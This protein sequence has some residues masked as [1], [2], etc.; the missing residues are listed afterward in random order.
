MAP[1]TLQRAGER[2]ALQGRHALTVDDG[3]AHLAAGLAGLGI[4]GLSPNSSEWVAW[5]SLVALVCG[6]ML[7]LARVLRLGFLGDFLSASVL[8]GFLTGVGIS[9]LT[10]QLPDLLVH[11]HQLTFKAMNSV[12]CLLFGT[13]R[14]A[15]MILLSAILRRPVT[16]PTIFG[17]VSILATQLADYPPSWR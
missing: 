9:V 4:S 12:T 8:I 5:T 3:N 1:L 11:E 6:A 16:C 10:G 2:V 15:R 17:T 14:P 13:R 7:I